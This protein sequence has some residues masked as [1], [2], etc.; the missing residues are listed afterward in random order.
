M[1]DAT[2]WPEGEVTAALALH[3]TAEI[4]IWSKQDRPVGRQLI[5][6]VH[7]I[8]AGADQITLCFHR[9]GAID[10]AHHKVIRMLSAESGEFIGWTVIRQG[11]SRVEVRQNNCFFWT[12]DFCGFSHEMN[13]A[14]HDHIRIGACRFS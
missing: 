6:Q 10:V 7:S 14:E 8:A 4:L 12:E 1:D 5:D 11:A 13:A 2:S 3:P 9:R